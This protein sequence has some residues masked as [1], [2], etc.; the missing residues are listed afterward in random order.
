MAMRLG[1]ENKRNRLI[2]M[3]VVPVALTLIAHAV[4][5]MASQGGSTASPAPPPVSTS[6]TA[7][8]SH[9]AQ[10]LESASELDPT[11][12]PEWMAMAENTRYTGTSRNIF[13]KDSLPPAQM[14]AMAK[15]IAPA[16]L[17]AAAA[18]T[19]P[20]PPPPIEL[21]FYGFATE[22]NGRKLI[23]LL[24]GEDIFIAGPGDVVDGRYK[25]VRI[26]GNSVTIQD[27]AYNDQQTLP[28]QTT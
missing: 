24:H 26:D 11:L 3:V 25:V 1:A 12:H 4:W 16:R 19:G 5:Q 15:P 13:S 18:D 23:F 17:S 6:T 28:L 9:T 21:K 10:R 2:A 27:L 8:S 7:S 14:Q 22:K 20:P